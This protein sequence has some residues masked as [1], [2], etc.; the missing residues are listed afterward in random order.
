MQSSFA[1]A[2]RILNPSGPFIGGQSELN[3]TSR[4]V[5]G[6]RSLQSQSIVETFGRPSDSTRESIPGDMS[7]HSIDEQCGASGCAKVP[8]P[9]P[10]SK[11]D[12]PGET[13]PLS[14]M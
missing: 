1:D 9:D 13:Y 5:P 14:S 3:A 2:S 12:L 10:M 6:G 8:G 4:A 7:V 11:R